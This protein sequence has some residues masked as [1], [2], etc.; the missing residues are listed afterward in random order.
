MQ[1]F[2]LCG[3]ASS[4]Q[5]DAGKSGRKLYAPDAQPFVKLIARAD[6]LLE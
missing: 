3:T 5:Y 6:E 4:G 1:A 2:A